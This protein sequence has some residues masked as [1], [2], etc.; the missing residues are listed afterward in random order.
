M[1][2]FI[3]W[4]LSLLKNR[5]SQIAYAVFFIIIFCLMRRVHFV[6]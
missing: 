6:T 5:I 3:H 1:N 4:L 2:V